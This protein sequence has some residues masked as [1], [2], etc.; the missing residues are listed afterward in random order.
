MTLK[1]FVVPSI[2]FKLIIYNPFDNE[3]RFNDFSGKNEKMAKIEGLDGL[4]YF[5][6]ASTVTI[7]I[8]AIKLML[9]DLNIFVLKFA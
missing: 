7:P 4:I 5:I 9:N 1:D 3:D 6:S 8:E 2:I